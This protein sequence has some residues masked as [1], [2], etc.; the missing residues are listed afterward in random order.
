MVFN[1]LAREEYKCSG[2]KLGIVIGHVL[3]LLIYVARK[4]SGCFSNLSIGEEW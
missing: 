3:K 2:G 1:G 4:R